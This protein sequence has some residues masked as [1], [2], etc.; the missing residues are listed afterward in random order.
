MSFDNDSGEPGL[1]AHGL[2]RTCLPTQLFVFCPVN[3]PEAPSRRLYK[4]RM[5][6]SLPV[7]YQSVSPS[8][9]W[10]L[11]QEVLQEH[12]GPLSPMVIGSQ[13]YILLTAIMCCGPSE[14]LLCM[15]CFYMCIIINLFNKP[16]MITPSQFTDEETKAQRDQEV[17][18]RPQS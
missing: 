12:R 11:F 18:P 1:S 9:L 8:Q 6:F 10:L 14:H 5:S 13:D 3:L 4:S 17:F 2:P 15:T 7:P 16:V